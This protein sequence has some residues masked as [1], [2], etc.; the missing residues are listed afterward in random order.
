MAVI[1]GW[2]DFQHPVGG[3]VT[4][5]KNGKEHASGVCRNSGMIQNFREWRTGWWRE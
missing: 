3:E 5:N 1:Q 4:K 2:G